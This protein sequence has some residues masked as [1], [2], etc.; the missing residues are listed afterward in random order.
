MKQQEEWSIHFLININPKQID[1]MAPKATVKPTTELLK[2][3][4]V[5]TLDL[6]IL[7]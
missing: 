4:L 6:E 5:C 7:G 2:D 1:L 3:A